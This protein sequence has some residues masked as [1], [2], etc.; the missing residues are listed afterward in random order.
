MTHSE[1]LSPELKDLFDDLKKLPARDTRLAAR[2]RA[3]FLTEAVSLREAVSARAK[4]RLNV[5]NIFTFRKD[6]FAMNTIFAVI[7]ATTLIFGGAGTTAYASQDDLPNDPLYPVKIGLEDISLWFNSDPL[8]EVNMLM[9]MTQTRAQEMFSLSE[10]G[11]G[12]PASTTLRLELQTREALHI[13]TT[14]EDPEMEQA[15]LQIHNALQTQE[16]LMTQAQLHATDDTLQL[17]TQTRAMLQTRIRLVEDGLA[18]PEGFRN[19]VRNESQNRQEQFATPEPGISTP[20]A[21]VPA[22]NGTG[23]SPAGNGEPGTS[24][25]VP[26]NNG[27]SAPPQPIPNSNGNFEDPNPPQDG[28]DSVHPKPTENSGPADPGGDNGGGNGGGNKP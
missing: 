7:L 17:L 9:Q 6:K 10:T 21:I 23:Q 16:Q 18:D 24:P 14:L 27:Q 28:N 22:D 8:T 25:T 12:I 1:E 15:L 5:W 20:P 13:A 2:G 26:G 4:P 19:T 11:D 3:L